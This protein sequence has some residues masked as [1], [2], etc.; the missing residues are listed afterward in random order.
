MMESMTL[1][2]H[3]C[4]TVV[5]VEH[6]MSEISTGPLE[7]CVQDGAIRIHWGEDRLSYL[8]QSLRHLII[9]IIIITAY[10]V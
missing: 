9:I 3:V 8:L 4:L 1:P 10:F 2:D 5:D 7:L 6:W